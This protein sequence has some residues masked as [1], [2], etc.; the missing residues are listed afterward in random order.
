MLSDTYAQAHA[1]AKEDLKKAAEGKVTQPQMEQLMNLADT[2][3]NGKTI[4]LS[5]GGK[6]KPVEVLT[7]IFASMKP[8]VEPGAINLS[9]S[10]NSGA[11]EP[12]NF[13]NI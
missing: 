11:I 1:K 10:D 9:D 13:E 3:E 7:E 4:E 5:D 6:K 2:F 12:I 8:K